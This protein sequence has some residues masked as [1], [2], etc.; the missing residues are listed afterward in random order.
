M[1]QQHP[2]VGRKLMMTGKKLIPRGINISGISKPISVLGLGTTSYAF[3]NKDMA[4]QMLDGFV[5]FGGTVIDTARAYSNGESEAVIGE[6]LRERGGREE[7]V[8]ITKG[9]HGS[10][11]AL[12]SENFKDLIKYELTE[13]LEAL[14]VNYIDLYLLHRDNP[15]LSVARIMDTL[16]EELNKGRIQA[17]GASNWTY[18]RIDE[19]NQYV[20]GH[21][22]RG[23][24]AI[25][26]NISLAVPN[27]PFYP[28][29]VSTGP[30]GEKWH[31][32]TKLPLMSW[33]SMARG[34]FTGRYT[35]E[36]CENLGKIENSFMKRMIEIYG[37]GDNFNRL[38]R[39][40][41][42]GNK[43]GGFT[44]PEI[45]LAWVLNRPYPVA[46]MVGP[47]TAKNLKSCV[48]ASL[49]ELSESETAYLRTG[50]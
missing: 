37:T 2:S 29:L 48:K 38:R 41:E 50:E 43:K 24:S 25:S 8:L 44:A 35:P 5:K 42:L 20:N 30:S 36:M 16:N 11:G 26:N 19:A 3:S 28:G 49:L 31:Q 45:S 27:G 18:D 4:F 12:P 10:E 13:S 21:G 47:H 1:I 39:A 34:F 14:G 22:L 15:V 46:A 33:S 7:I 32:K 23:F 6:W 40:E 17:F 9:G